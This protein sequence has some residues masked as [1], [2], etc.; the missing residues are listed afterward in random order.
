[1]WS[2]SRSVGRRLLAVLA[3]CIAMNEA[4]WSAG[5]DPP[6]DKLDPLQ[7]WGAWR[8]PL[9]NGTAPHG[10]PPLRFSESENF[11]WKADL[12]GEG[13]L[14]PIIW[15]NRVFVTAAEPTDKK[16]PPKDPDPRSR[17][18][19]PDVFYRFLVLC[20]DR[21]SGRELWRRTATEAVPSEGRHSTNTYAGGSPVTDGQRLYVSFGTQGVYCYSLDGD[22]LWSRKLGVLRTRLGWGQASTPGLGGDTLVVNWDQEDD[23]FVVALDAATGEPKWKK[24][25]PEE[26]TSW[27]VPLIVRQGEKQQ[28][29]INA[30]GRTRAY[31]LATGD[32]L[33]ECGGQTVNAIPSPVRIDDAVICMSG[34]R[35]SAAIA[36]P[37]ET[38][39][40]VTGQSGR[41]IWSH[42]KDTPYVPSPLLYGD[43]LVFTKTLQPIAS[44]LNARTGEVMREAV[45][46]PRLKG[47][48]ASPTAAAGRI[49][50]VG[51]E[52]GVVVCRADASLEVLAEFSLPDGF[53]AS[54]A[55]VGRQ[56]FLRGRKTL[57]CFQSP[58]P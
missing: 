41:V 33:W 38:R 21:E 8:G 13:A 37:L 35:G 4:Q 32:V 52:G 51:R 47:L 29:V 39:G 7:Q 20:F 28:V 36:I 22:L 6:A 16:A 18:S 43:L 1:M 49:Y 12:P 46:L 5:Q 53:D 23:S 54:P 30:T 3:V 57:Y 11:A 44:C 24:S 26:P 19:P 9:E 42:G 17:T 50:F 27:S 48:Y 56:L 34:Y 40:D 31:D 10:D 55:I 2:G 15:G 14:T 25:R 58:A 45:R